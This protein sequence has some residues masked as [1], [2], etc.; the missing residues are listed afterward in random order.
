MTTYGG[1]HQGVSVYRGSRY[2][3]ERRPKI[4][5]GRRVC[6]EDGCGTVLSRYNLGDLCRIHAPIT[7]PRVRG[8]VTGPD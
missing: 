7:F 1:S 8:N 4:R 2:G 5:E 6:T 3:S